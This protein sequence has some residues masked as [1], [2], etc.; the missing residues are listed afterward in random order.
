M[1]ANFRSS[2]VHSSQHLLFNEITL[3]PDILVLVGEPGVVL[4]TVGGEAVTLGKVP[5][6]KRDITNSYA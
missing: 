4:V 1:E 3:S 5:V 6:K 2:L